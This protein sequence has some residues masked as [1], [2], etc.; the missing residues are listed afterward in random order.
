L[1]VPRPPSPPHQP[2]LQGTIE[3]SPT[4]LVRHGRLP[5]L[6]LW[7][8]S[9]VKALFDEHSFWAQRRS[10]RD[11]I[12]MLLGSCSVVSVWSRRK[13]IGLG[14]ATSDGIFRAVLWDVVVA[15]DYRSQGMGRQLVE[16]LLKTPPVARAERVYLMT[17][18]SSGFYAKLGFT[19]HHG[20]NLLV[21]YKKKR[22]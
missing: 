14:R 12:R 9:Q 3:A 20:Q 16:Q 6:L 18:N 7:R 17:T 21:L 22:D 4:E 5:L 8:I 1:T 10:R 2:V 11:L 19:K 13:L 15:A